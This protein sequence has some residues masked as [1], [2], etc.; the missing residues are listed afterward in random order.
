MAAAHSLAQDRIL[1]M[2]DPRNVDYKYLFMALA[3]VVVMMF[4][5]ARGSNPLASQAEA[6]ARAE[7]RLTEA[8]QKF[9]VAE[10]K[11]KAKTDERQ[12]YV[13]VLPNNWDQLLALSGTKLGEAR[14]AME[15]AEK[16]LDTK[17]R[18]NLAQIEKLMAQASDLQAEAMADIQSMNAA[19]VQLE[20][21]LQNQQR[22]VA[23]A[24]E[25]YEAIASKSFGNVQAQVS[26]ASADWPEKADDLQQRLQ[27]LQTMVR[28]AESEYQ[29][30]LAEN[31]KSEAQTDFVALAESIQAL[32]TL[33]IGVESGASTLESLI[34][35][36]Y[37]SRDVILTDMDRSGSTYRHKLKTII[38]PYL[39]SETT[40]SPKTDEQ[41]QNV[42]ASAYRQNENNLGMVISHKPAGKYEFEAGETAQPPGYAYMAPIG[43]SNQYG[44]WRRDNSG[45]SFWVFYGQYALMRD[46]LWGPRTHYVYGS[47][48][49]NYRTNYSAGRPYYGS[50]ASSNTQTY[51]SKGSFTQRNYSSSRYMSSQGFGGSKYSS[52]SSR[53]GRR[54]SFGGGSRGWGGK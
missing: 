14:A 38:T 51:G 37:Y 9:E 29:N 18:D 34:A 25:D 2:S 28:D 8:S 54:S 39:D 30:V 43:Q 12:A 31:T 36:L 44:E 41:W 6:H 4:L 32:D 45:R 46:L 22:E 1:S 21:L 42:S 10:A 20:N 27:T 48:Y 11:I 50:T 52:K 16:L 7:A 35:Q 19:V 47:S 53:G 26:K 49:N 23:G 24:K 40:A 13:Q 17:D 15:Q 5:V 33:R 3:V